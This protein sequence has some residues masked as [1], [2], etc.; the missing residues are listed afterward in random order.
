MVEAEEDERMQIEWH[1]EAEAERV[2]R[3]RWQAAAAVGRENADV[4][5]EHADSSIDACRII[6]GIRY[7][8]VRFR[9]RVARAPSVGFCSR[10][11]WTMETGSASCRIIFI[12]ICSSGLR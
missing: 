11:Q 3:C 8:R 10:F 1:A 9:G 7:F 4:R 2:G 12:I 5:G 6:L